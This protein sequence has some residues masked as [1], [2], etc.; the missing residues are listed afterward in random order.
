MMQIDHHA[1]ALGAVLGQVLDAQGA[2]LGALVPRPGFRII[3]RRGGN[4]VFAGAETVVE[5]DLALAVAVGIEA[6][7]DVGKAVPLR[8]VLQREQYP[9]VGN[10]VGQFRLVLRLR[11]GAAEVP[12]L[13]LNISV[14]GLIC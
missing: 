8:G 3:S 1:T 5:D 12:G 9:V 10:D 6:A 14:L 2:G 11:R 7:A 4:D 13:L